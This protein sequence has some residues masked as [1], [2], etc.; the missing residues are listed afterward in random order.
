MIAKK[1]WS[2]TLVALVAIGI[3]ACGGDADADA[4]VAETQS[5][6]DSALGCGYITQTE[7]NELDSEYEAI[8]GGLVKMMAEAERWC[9][10]S[11]LVKE[12]AAVYEVKP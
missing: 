12:E 6:L 4:E 1:S 9:G 2:L 3:A 8:S 7:F 5:W 11:Q 10:P